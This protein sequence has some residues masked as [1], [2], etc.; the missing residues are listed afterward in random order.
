MNV[1]QMKVETDSDHKTE[2]T[3]WVTCKSVEDI[4]DIGAWLELAK[5]F[6]SG[7]HTVVAKRAPAKASGNVSPINKGKT[8]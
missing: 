8:P 7:W 3:L 1:T 5:D 2:V 6:V 4:E